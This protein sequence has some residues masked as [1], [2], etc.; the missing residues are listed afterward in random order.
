MAEKSEYHDNFL[1][2]QVAAKGGLDRDA[3]KKLFDR[4]DWLDNLKRYALHDRELAIISASI[5]GDM[6]WLPTMVKKYRHLESLANWYNF[7]WRPIFCGEY[8]E[9]TKLSLLRNIA[10]LA[11]KSS[12]RITLY[13]LPNEENEVKLLTYAFKQAGWI[14]IR[15]EADVNHILRLNGRTFDDY[16]RTRPG[17]LRST[18]KRKSKKNIVSIRIEKEFNPESWDDYE[19][20]YEKSWKTG[21][22]NPEFL[23]ELAKQE[24]EAGALRLGL[25]YI[26][27][28]CVAAQF[29]TVENGEALIHK[30]AHD[31][32]YL[33]ASPGTLLSAGLF[34]HVIDVDH[35][36]IIDF[37]T[38]DDKYKSDWMEEIRTRYRLDLFHPNIPLSWPYIAKHYLLRL[39]KREK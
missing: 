13:P 21:E 27:G 26:D 8:D 28:I 1:S 36:N 31:E 30:L 2:V 18:V 37:G 38:G 4:L 16:W 22:G 12:Y 35:V 25:A 17:Q 6:A 20:V 11:K 9:V 29:W 34:Q 23:R 10:A 33:S 32:A 5:N 15:E 19:R 7:T 24:A 39:A 14:A 3:Q